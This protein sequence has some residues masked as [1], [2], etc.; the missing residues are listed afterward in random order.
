[1]ISTRMVLVLLALLAV[2]VAVA[3]AVWLLPGF[4]EGF[5]AVG[6]VLLLLVLFVQNVLG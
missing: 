3:V 5:F 2:I 6:F 4:R 1:M